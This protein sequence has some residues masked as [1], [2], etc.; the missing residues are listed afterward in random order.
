[1]LSG[2]FI[3]QLDAMLEDDDSVFAGRNTLFIRNPDPKCRG[4]FPSLLEPPLPSALNSQ[5]WS[6]GFHD[7]MTILGDM[8]NS[9]IHLLCTGLLALAF[10]IGCSPSR[11]T[12]RIN[13]VVFFKLKAA[14]DVDALIQ[15]CDRDLS[16]IPGVASYF[17]GQHGDFGRPMVDSDYDVG[18]YVGFDSDEA[19]EAYLE[20]PNHVDLVTKW[21]PRWSWIRIYDVL[22][23]TP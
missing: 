12:A 1:M 2:E 8:G 17:C 4:D 11:R 9:R 19:Y 23:D 13:H 7:S 3:P 18:F 22:D 21:K 10:L 16:S 6:V 5:P 20:H 14:Q 15:D